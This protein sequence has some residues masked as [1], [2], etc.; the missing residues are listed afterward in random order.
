MAMYT[1]KKNGVTYSASTTEE[2]Q[3]LMSALKLNSEKDH[4]QDAD[5]ASDKDA[6]KSKKR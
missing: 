3:I 1:I 5:A 4:A 6:K 2:L